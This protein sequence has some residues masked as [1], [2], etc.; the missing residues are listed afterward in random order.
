MS[1]RVAEGGTKEGFVTMTKGIGAGDQ[2]PSYYVGYKKFRKA[3]KHV[4]EFTRAAL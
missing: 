4:L 3:V 1:P 2:Q